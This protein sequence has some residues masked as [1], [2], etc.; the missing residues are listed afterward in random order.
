MND[1][2]EKI[3]GPAMVKAADDV[4]KPDETTSLFDRYVW[5]TGVAVS[6]IGQD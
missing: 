1:D 4:L 6:F 3:C 5:H 2:H